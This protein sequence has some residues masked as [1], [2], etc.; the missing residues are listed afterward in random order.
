M[1]GIKGTKERR[2]KK[3]RGNAPILRHGARDKEKKKERKREGAV[4]EGKLP[5][6]S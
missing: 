3:G 2:R 6:I 1:G 5:L 4:G